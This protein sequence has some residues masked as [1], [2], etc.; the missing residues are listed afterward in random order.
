MKSDNKKLIISLAMAFLLL[1]PQAVFADTGPKPSVT[2]IVSG[3]DDEYIVTLLASVEASGPWNSQ[4]TYDDALALDC[5]REEWNALKNYKDADG[6]Y[7]LGNEQKLKGRGSY[8]WSYMRPREFKILVYVPED[9]SFYCSE[10]FDSYA[11]DSIYDVEIKDG[12]MTAEESY[13]AAARIIA[14][15]GRILITVA[16]ELVIAFVFGFGK[17]PL[18][19][20]I[21]IA[22]IVTQLI[23]NILLMTNGY[24]SMMTIGLLFYGPYELIVVI[25]EIIIYCVSFK[26]LGEKAPKLRI[27]LY[28]LIA[29]AASYFLGYFIS[30]AFPY[31]FK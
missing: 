26:K 25:A 11:F 10:A 16:V 31:L 28:T 12:V 9:G 4:S 23:L 19:R 2:V 29:N 1:L 14:L 3:I 13:H 27:I 6:F 17:K 30:D 21:V 5:S 24:A 7:F 18:I 20:V 8:E 15:I 22:N